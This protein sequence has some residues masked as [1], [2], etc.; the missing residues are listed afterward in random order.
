MAYGLSFVR[1]EAH[2]CRSTRVVML[3]VLGG[4]STGAFAAEGGVWSATADFASDTWIDTGS[5]LASPASWGPW[6]WGIFAAGATAVGVSMATV[7]NTTRTEAQEN[8][9]SN[10]DNMA[11]LANT[12]GT[13]FSLGVLAVSAGVGWIA[14]ERRPLELARDGLEAS[15]I[16]TL[17]I[18]PLKVVVGRSRPDQDP[19]GSDDYQ[20][21]SGNYSFPS[22]HTSQAFAIA[23]VVANTYNDHWWAGALA[24]GVAGTVGYA[25]INDNQHYLS[26]VIAGALIGGAIGWKVVNLNRARRIS[27]D[28]TAQL[29]TS[30]SHS[31]QTVGIRLDF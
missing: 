7:D 16:T 22:G 10:S 26:D 28:V 20:P 23:S 9:N 19:N 17:I 18:T 5:V 25:R 3:V 29:S 6:E 2:R 27:A 1:H 12:L 30:W 4:C 14:H 21:F 31:G 13:G 24:Y 8:R 11:H 15:I